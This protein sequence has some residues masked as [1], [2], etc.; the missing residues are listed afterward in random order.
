M[1]GWL[2][3]GFI[4]ICH[5]LQIVICTYLL[6]APALQNNFLWS[7]TAMYLLWSM[8]CEWRWFVSLKAGIWYMMRFFFCYLVGNVEL[9]VTPS[10]WILEWRRHGKGLSWLLMNRRHE[11]KVIL[12]CK[13]ARL[14][15][16][17]FMTVA[18][19][20]LTILFPDMPPS[21]Q[22]SWDPWGGSYL[23][24]KSSSSSSQT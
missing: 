8:N 15:E 16:G 6:M 7:R 1:E 21:M 13:S 20:W 19:P 3:K 12:Y 23:P 14:A 11:C 2:W 24:W 9:K 17:A 4:T 10:S 22:R 18:C 5:I